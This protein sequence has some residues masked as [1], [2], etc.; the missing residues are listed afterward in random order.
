MDGINFGA[1]MSNSSNMYALGKTSGEFRN[2]AVYV[3]TKSTDQLRSMD[4][5]CTTINPFNIIN[6]F[7]SCAGHKAIL[8]GLFE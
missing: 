3:R 8:M 2:I 6:K 5:T 7:P 4:V 1:Q